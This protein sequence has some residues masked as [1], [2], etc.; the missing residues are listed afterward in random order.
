MRLRYVL[1]VLAPVVLNAQ[2]IG[3]GVN[4]YSIE[5]EMAV[6][7]ELARGYRNNHA[8]LNDALIQD[9][10]ESVGQKLIVALPQQSPFPYHFELTADFNGTFVEPT[11]FPGGYIFV[12]AGLILEA[13]DES[14]FAG[15]LAHS[16]A[17]ILAR[18]STRQATRAEIA[19]LATDSIPLIF[20]AGNSPQNGALVPAGLLQF[21]R[22]YES[23][24]DLI[25][26]N[27]AAAAGYDPTG[28][29]HYIGRE[30]EDPA[31]QAAFSAFPPRES[32]VQAMERAIQA[33]PQR[34]YA[35]SAA[36]FGRVQEDLKR[37]LPP[38][39]PAKP[40]TLQR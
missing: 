8:P 31:V 23:E 32:R 35:S 6:G 25:A 9:Y 30:Q 26:V 7:A 33:L 2:N 18:H 40:P 12:P 38:P 3:K 13:K 14:E 5:K 15:M 39:S 36:D 1:A 11:S 34:T 22:A 27:M 10:V 19:Q 24:A 37:L 28:L 20:V 21:Q 16:M 17:H 4:F 29:E